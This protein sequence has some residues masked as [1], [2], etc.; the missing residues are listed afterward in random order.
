MAIGEVQS[1]SLMGASSLP[2]EWRGVQSERRGRQG[3]LVHQL[4]GRSTGMVGL[5]ALLQGE[6]SPAWFGGQEVLPL[7]QDCFFAQVTRMS[8]HG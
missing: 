4:H 2:A 7:K 6:W 5:S 1:G 3:G 8:S